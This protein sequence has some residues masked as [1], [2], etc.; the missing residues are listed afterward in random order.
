MLKRPITAGGLPDNQWL[1]DADNRKLHSD[2]SEEVLHFVVHSLVRAGYPD[3]A[4]FVRH[5]ELPTN[6]PNCGLDN[7]VAEEIV[8]AVNGF[9]AAREALQQFAEC[10]LN[11]DNCA[12]LEVATARIRNL[13]RKAL[14]PQE[15][16]R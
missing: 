10:D 13:A 16:G 9:A 4:A 2:G 11:E 3:A 15:G 14:A 7:E 6:V 12:S 1:F 8:A 5:L